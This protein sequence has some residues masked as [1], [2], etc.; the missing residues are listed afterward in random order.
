M[1]NDTDNFDIKEKLIEKS[2]AAYILA[3]ETINRI[4]IQ[5]RLEAFCILICNAWEL[6]LKAKILKRGDTIHS[7]QGS[8]N[9]NRKTISLSQ[10]LQRIMPSE[11]DPMRRN[12]ERIK[13]LRDASIHHIMDIDS[14]P[15]NVIGLFQ[16]SVINYHACLHQWFETSLSD[17]FPVGMMSITYDRDPAQLD[18]NNDHLRQRL[19]QEAA[20]FLVQYC[21]GIEQEFNQLQRSAQFSIGFEYKL[22]LTKKT[23][24]A[25]IAL[26]SGPGG[27]ETLGVVYA[28]KDSS[29]SH[30]FRETEVLEQLK[31]Y[32][33]TTV[34][35]HDIRCIVRIYKVKKNCQYFYQGKVKSSPPQYSQF[36]VDWIVK[37]W[38]KDEKF[39]CKARKKDKENRKHRKS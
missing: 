15:H 35:Q 24:E 28:P 11:T 10:C 26:S 8:K 17:R 38:K 29:H 23:D 36:F 21:T 39:F 33:I 5:Y 4:A 2:L 7:N 1:E 27:S 9:G 32:T 18:W 31:K 30:P 16:A 34:N 37:Q 25:D 3:L 12:V 6:L 14:I 13:E 20:M 19:G 22:V